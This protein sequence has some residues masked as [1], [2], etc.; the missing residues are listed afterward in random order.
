MSDAPDPRPLSPRDPEPDLPP[1]RVWHF[2]SADHEHEHWIENDPAAAAALLTEY[3]DRA[4][5]FTLHH[6]TDA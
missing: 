3:S 5:P 1:I 4:Q 6:Y 2:L